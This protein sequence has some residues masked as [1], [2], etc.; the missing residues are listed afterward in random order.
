MA[1]RFLNIIFGK[2]AYIT[3][4]NENLLVSGQLTLQVSL[5]QCPQLEWEMGFCKELGCG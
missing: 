3:F 2:T 4:E 1:I 5:T